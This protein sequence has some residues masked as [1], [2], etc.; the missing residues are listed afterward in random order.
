[1]NLLRD[2]QART[3]VALLFVAHDLAVVQNVAHDVAVMY[4]GRIVE[5]GPAEEVLGRPTHPY[6]Q[7]LLSS[8]PAEHPSLRGAGTRIRLLG[9][10]PSPAAPPSGCRFRTR[11]SRATSD[12]AREVPALVPRPGS[13]HPSACLYA[14]RN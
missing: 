2:I 12:C 1:V 8:I 11:C 14:A 5:H 13:P 9:D 7:A 4:L 3:G 10:P 6:T